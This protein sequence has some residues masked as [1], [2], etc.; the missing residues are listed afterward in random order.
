MKKYAC[1]LLF[2]IMLNGC[3]DG[4]LTAEIIDFSEIEPVS[5]SETNELLYKLKDQESLLLQLPK[6]TLSPENGIPELGSKEYSITSGGA[7][8]LVYRA[9]DG[10]I[11]KSNICDAIRPSSPNVSNEWFATGGK[12]KIETSPKIETNDTNGSSRIIGFNHAIYMQNITYS[13]PQGEQV[14]PDF[15]F[16][17]LIE[18]NYTSPTIAFTNEVGQCST[19]YQLYNSTATSTMTIDAVDSKLIVNEETFGTARTS[20]ITS[21]QNKIVYNNYINGTI[22]TAYFCNTTR[23]T[24]PEIDETWNGAAGGTIEVTTTKTGTTFFHTITLKNVVLENGNLNFKLG[25]S[26]LFGV[27]TKS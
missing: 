16:G 23:P 6:Y 27:L 21:T 5:C 9:Y 1:L 18:S 15:F 8:Q 10:V 13:K 4:D 17:N 7:Y 25:N 12:I 24:S 19:T 3:D 14:N 11:S 26:F 20:N 22:S 2:A